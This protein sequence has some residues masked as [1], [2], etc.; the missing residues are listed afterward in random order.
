VTLDAPAAASDTDGVGTLPEESEIRPP[1]A[2]ELRACRILLPTATGADRR[3][4]LYVAVSGTPQRVVGAAA[5]GLDARRQTHEGWQ[6]DLHVIPPVRRRGIG[7]ALL[8]RVLADA[9]AHQV[10]ALHAWEWVEPDSDAARAW[11][12]LGFAPARRKREYEADIAAASSTLVPLYE[13][14]RA[15]GYI[16]PAAKILP[17]SEAD[18]AAVADLHVEYLGGSRRLLMPLLTGAAPDA[19]HP[20]YSRII[21]L[22]GRVVGASL[23]RVLPGGVCEV[24]AHVLHP[25]VRMG[26]ANLW[27]KMEAAERLLEDGVRTMRYFTLEQHTDTHRI[28]RQA[29]CRLLRTVV[30]MRRVLSGGAGAGGG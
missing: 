11:A 27:L 23:G 3:A 7:R 1:T 22:D 20:K 21:L 8:D 9:E 15:S 19:Y 10:P 24:D 13:Q 5:L 4:R 29:G 28:S 6:V 25:S 30:Q 26:W 16:P 2:V 14:V 18:A 17:L 12:A